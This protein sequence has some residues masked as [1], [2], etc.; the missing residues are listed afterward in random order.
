M[1]A[2][3]LAYGRISSFRVSG[4][5]G[6]V[7]ADA[8]G[9]RGR[10]PENYESWI[11]ECGGFPFSGLHPS[12]TRLR[13]GQIPNRPILASRIGCKSRTT[14]DIYIYIYIYV[15]VYIYI[16]IY[17]TRIYTVYV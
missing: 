15:Y 11:N 4:V 6:S 13:L 17:Y 14:T 3:I 9:P 5:T 1:I 12:K 2:H 8:A 10:T 16:Y 7:S